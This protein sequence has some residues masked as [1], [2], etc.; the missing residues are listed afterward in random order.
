MTEFEQHSRDSVAQ[1]FDPP[2]PGSDHLVLHQ[3][4]VL[5]AG[6]SYALRLIHNVVHVV[7][8]PTPVDAVADAAPLNAL[9]RINRANDRF[10]RLDGA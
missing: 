4:P 1:T 3:L 9:Q 10:W 6:R 8:V 5:A 2:A 7:T